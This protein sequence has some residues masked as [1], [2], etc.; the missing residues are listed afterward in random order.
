[1]NLFLTAPMDPT[2][3]AE[4]ELDIESLK[5]IMDGFDPASLLPELDAMF[6]AVTIV[7]RLAVM[8]APVVLLVMGLCY[9]ILSPKEANYYF[10]YRCYY[11][12][13]SVRAWQFTQRMAGI[14]L[15]GLGLVLSVVML[16]VSGGYAAM[17]VTDVVH[18]AAVCLIWEAVLSILAL[19]TINA[20]AMYRFDSKGALRNREKHSE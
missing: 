17:T 9:L 13:G 7:C 14:V 18:S 10:G 3:A 20:T 16:F 11:G 2:A 8:V 1:M 5:K 19:V 15:G 12:M 4:A 6:G